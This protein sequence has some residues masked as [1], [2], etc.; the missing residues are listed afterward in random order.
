[1]DKAKLKSFA[2]E[3][4]RNLIKNISERLSILGFRE[5]EIDKVENLRREVS[6]N[7]IKIKK[8]QYDKLNKSFVELGYEEFVERVAYT[9]FNRF[10]ALRFMELNGYIDEAITTSTTSKIEPDVIDNYGHSSFFGSLNDEE[11]N[12]IN[13]LRDAEKIEELYSKILKLKC[14]ELNKVMPFMFEEKDNFTELL[15]PT[16][17]LREK[18]FLVDLRVAITNDDKEEVGEERILPVE[19]IGWLYQFYNSE[20]KDLLFNGLQNRKQYDKNDIAP[21]TQLF[22]PSWIVKYITENTLGRLALERLGVDKKIKKNWEFFLEPKEGLNYENKILPESIKILDPAMGSGHILIYAFDVLFQIY[23]N[24]G[25]SAK[26]SVQSILNDNIYGLEIDERAGQ[27]ATFALIMKGREKFR[28]LFN[29]LERKEIVLK[30]C[31]IKE[32]NYLSENTKQLIIENK[33]FELNYLI[34]IF[35]DA[36]EYGSI[37][38]L[39]NVDF[40][41]LEKEKE[42]LKLK[43]SLF[44]SLYDNLLEKLIEQAKIMTK[45]FDI[46]IENP[47]YMNGSRMN[48]KAKIYIEKD[49]AY[50]K[51]KSDMFSV[52]FVKSCDY[53]KEDGYLG[54]MSPFVWM[55]IKSYEE[56]RKFFIEQKTITSLVQLEYSAFEEATVPICTFTIKNRKENIK[57]EYI[58]LSDFKGAAAQPVKVKESIENPDVDFRYSSNQKDF[59]KIPGSPI[60][61][62]VSDRVKEIFEKSEKLGDVG[63]AKQGLA[64][65]DNDRFIRLWQE[66]NIAK[67]GFGMKNS[68][69][70]LESLKKW[71]PYNK[72]GEKR[73]WYGNQEYLVNWENDGDEIRNFKNSVIRNPTF[74][75]RESISWSD[76]SSSGNSFRVFPK[77][78]IHDVTG[79]SYFI[80]EKKNEFLLLGILN[81]KLIS[82][83]TKIINPTLHLQIGDIIKLPYLVV[84]ENIFDILVKQNVFIAKQE[85]DSRETS[86]DFLSS[87]LLNHSSISSAFNSYSIYWTEQFT[88]MHKNEE[89]LNKMFIEIYG[90]QDEMDKN[91]E[92]KDITLLKKEIKIQNILTPPQRKEEQEEINKTPEGYL[93]NR[94]YI[95]EFSK[96]EISKQFISYCVGIIMGRYSLDKPGLIMANSDDKLVVTGDSYEVLGEEGEVRHSINSSKYI[97]DNDAIIPIIA[98]TFAFEDS[99][100]KRFEEVVTAIYGLETLEENLDFIADALDRKK[101]E[102]A[103]ET[104]S[105]YFMNDFMKDHV[106]RYKKR[107]IYWLFTSGKTKGFNALVYMHRYNPMTVA[108]LRQDYLLKYQERLESR[109]KSAHEELEIETNAKDKKNIEKRVKGLQVQ[110]DEIKKYDE[111]VKHMAEE[112]LDI[113]LDDGVKVNYAKFGG[114]LYKI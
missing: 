106:Q 7:N 17:L 97:P 30:S 59:E 37:L 90:L 80:R 85:W 23:E 75:F 39:R 20:K 58:K 6:V 109:I 82:N 54:F 15:F 34:E 52:F 18:S 76:I 25:Y 99:I 105:K 26:E 114:L 63:D 77:G 36:K 69:E 55:F 88:Q 40:E 96:S 14:S 107:P 12:E 81:N 56:L 102:T 89:E 66:I 45:K 35:H 70:A 5:N 87:P 16:G 60:A 24:L 108:K 31:T 110:F 1:M 42:I 113:N 104:I 10:I 28:R 29:I 22:T 94:G 50:S 83:I 68:Q 73:K 74:Y 92:L 33:L 112:K 9:W 62:W 3:S 78:F 65:A 79:M 43:D 41:K 48:P 64:T 2:I 51:V 86:W 111:E 101:G 93:Y 44:Y 4:R 49:E 13:N 21:A 91:V 100:A 98:D 19:M 46:V 95:L 38:K 11:K 57:G 103:R 53:A 61:Y 47:P 67:A 84:K 27:L 71:F 72:G 8:E 32:S